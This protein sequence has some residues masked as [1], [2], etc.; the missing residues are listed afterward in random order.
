M[1]REHISTM[2]MEQCLNTIAYLPKKKLTFTTD[3]ELS[4]F[5]HPSGDQKNGEW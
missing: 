2:L 1:R 5:Y 4:G 3:P